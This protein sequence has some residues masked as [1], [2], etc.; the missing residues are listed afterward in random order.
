METNNVEKK[1]MIILEDIYSGDYSLTLL[2]QKLILETE[3]SEIRDNI[4]TEILKL[5]EI[6]ETIRG[7]TIKLN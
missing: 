4:K 5:D 6:A 3:A 7:I 2:S 1:E